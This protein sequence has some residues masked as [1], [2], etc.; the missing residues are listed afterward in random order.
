MVIFPT[1]V[2]LARIQTLLP[3]AGAPLRLPRTSRQDG[4]HT[5]TLEARRHGLCLPVL[6]YAQPAEHR[7]R[8][9]GRARGCSH[10]C[11]RRGG[12]TRTSDQNARHRPCLQRARRGLLRPHMDRGRR[13]TGARVHGAAAHRN[14]L[15]GTRGQRT[16]VAFHICPTVSKIFIK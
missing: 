10:T 5:H 8:Y 6:R 13:H 2:E 3:M 12:R 16:P 7:Q 1:T 9:R 15:C 14:R 11:R 4:P